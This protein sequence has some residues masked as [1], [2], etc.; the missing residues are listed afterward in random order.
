ME[1][2]NGKPKIHDE[3]M[4]KAQDAWL[5]DRTLEQSAAN[6][7][8]MRGIAL[9]WGRYD[10]TPTHVYANQSFSRKLED[11][12]IEHEAEEYRGSPWSNYFTD[13][14]RFYTRLLPFLAEHLVFEVE[15]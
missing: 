11:L 13:N 7:R 10:P 4:K 14:G 3:H 5:L 12:G 2:E 8:K 15:N 6:L 1:L 9:D